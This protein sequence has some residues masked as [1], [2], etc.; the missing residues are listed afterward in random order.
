MS[1]KTYSEESALTYLAKFGT[2]KDPKAIKVIKS[3]KNIG[4]KVLG[5]VDFLVSHHNYIYAGNAKASESK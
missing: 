3:S 5:A 1:K 2:H 4:I